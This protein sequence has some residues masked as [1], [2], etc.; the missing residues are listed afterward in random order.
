GFNAS[1][2]ATPGIRI[3]PVSATFDN[4]NGIAIQPDG[5]IVTAGYFGVSSPSADQDIVLVRYNP[6]GSLDAKPSSDTMPNV[7]VTSN[8]Q[9]VLE[10]DLSSLLHLTEDATNQLRSATLTL[11]YSS[12]A[13]AYPTSFSTSTTQRAAIG[14]TLFFVADNRLWRTDGTVVGTRE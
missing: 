6:D 9:G 3:T 14:D 11:D 10:F 5:K 1:S 4:V 2:L 7:S 8:S 13:L 12:T